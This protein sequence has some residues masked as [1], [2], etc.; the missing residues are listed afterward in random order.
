MH[1]MQS[2]RYANSPITHQLQRSGV[3]RQLKREVV[4]G[5]DRQGVAGA[6]VAHVQLHLGHLAG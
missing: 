1:S 2:T 5:A 6:L 3:H 4:D